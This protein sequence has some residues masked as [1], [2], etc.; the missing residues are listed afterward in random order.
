MNNPPKAFISYSHENKEARR[1]LV[2]HLAV[3]VNQNKLTIWDDS[4]M[5]GGDVLQEEILKNLTASDILFYLVS[6]ASL[7]SPACKEELENALSADIKVIPIILERC[8]WLNDP[9]LR[10]FLAFPTDGEPINTRD[11]ESEGWYD[12]VKGIRGTVEKMQS[13][14]DS[15]SGEPDEA[16]R[17]ENAFDKGNNAQI[18]ILGQLNMAIEAYSDAIA[19]DPR[20]AVAYI[21]RGVAYFRSG[22]VDKAIDDYSQAIVLQ[23]AIA[24]YNKAIEL[25]PD[26]AV[27]YYYRGLAYAEKGDFDEAIA[28]FTKAIKLNPDYF[29]AYD[30]RGT[31]YGQ[32]KEFDNAINDFGKA[33]DRSPNDPQAYSNRG[34]VYFQQG[35][36]KRAI[37]DY[38][39][40]IS[41]KRDYAIA[42]NNLGTAYLWKGD[43]R[44]AIQNYNTAIA[45]QSNYPEAYY[46]RGNAYFREG[47]YRQAI[48][49]Y[50]EAMR[51]SPDFV[52]A[53]RKRDVA[54]QRLLA[55]RQ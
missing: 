36:I 14:A 21:N 49:D 19:L 54:L 43:L 51:L 29:E 30:G 44:R 24:N 3:M 50:E 9:Q 22:E 6:A 28:D 10:K 52:G 32:K 26:L 1:K 27:A 23:T 47:D 42:Y 35:E 12:V 48:A 53:Q 20:Y 4:R 37:Q 55:S 31:A 5:D 46:G 45:L 33:I 15:S 13:Q 11:P 8:D 39:T 7:A 18:K 16:L 25:D 40:A 2:T 41:L 17:A 34:T 38:N